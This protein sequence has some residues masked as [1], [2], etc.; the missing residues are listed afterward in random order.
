MKPDK[1]KVERLITEIAQDLAKVRA[2]LPL[3]T[4]ADG[5]YLQRQIEKYLKP[6]STATL[7]EIW[8][9]RLQMSLEKLHEFFADKANREKWKIGGDAFKQQGSFMNRAKLWAAFGYAKLG[10]NGQAGE[11]IVIQGK[12]WLLPDKILA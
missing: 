4:S 9:G 6:A 8:R 1:R 11:Q 2:A 7:E 12:A 10:G 5:V 3:P